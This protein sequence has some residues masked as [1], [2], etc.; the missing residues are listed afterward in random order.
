MT[1]LDDLNQTIGVALTARSHH[2]HGILSARSDTL[3]HP[4]TMS[5]EN[6]P[7]CADCAH[8]R[9]EDDRAF[10]SC[11]VCQQPVCD[12]CAGVHECRAAITVIDVLAW[13][14]HRH[15][16]TRADVER[17]VRQAQ[18]CAAAVADTAAV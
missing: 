17:E 13:A 1:S 12:E 7:R 14:L 5:C 6:S 4:L 9:K 3:S 15:G 16:M 2:S 18:A 11:L 8:T 10:H